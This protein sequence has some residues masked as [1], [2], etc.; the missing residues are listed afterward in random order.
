MGRGKS[1]FRKRTVANG[2]GKELRVHTG[3]PSRKEKQTPQTFLESAQSSGLPAE[4]GFTTI[5]EKCA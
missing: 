3:Q 2:V 4:E 5:P 1:N